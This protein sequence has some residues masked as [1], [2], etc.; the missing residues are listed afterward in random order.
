MG[1][2]YELSYSD[3]LRCHD[4][5]T[6]FYKDWF[7]HLKVNSGDSQ[8]QRQY[9]DSI[10]LILFFQNEESGSRKKGCKIEY[11]NKEGRKKG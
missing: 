3:G 9:G 6:K 7:K 1:G 8:T 10:S 4:I 11:R 2:I 5:H